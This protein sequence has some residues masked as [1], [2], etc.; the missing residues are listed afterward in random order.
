MALLVYS[1]EEYLIAAYLLILMFSSCS[2]IK[3][4]FRTAALILFYKQFKLCRVQG[5]RN[6][7][8]A[9]IFHGLVAKNAEKA[10]NCGDV[11]ELQWWW[12]FF[13][14]K[15]AVAEAVLHF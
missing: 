6:S 5:I 13:Y 10:L 9:S 11:L 3:Q 7:R 8:A 12:I 14:L 4:F 15:Y 2:S 1:L